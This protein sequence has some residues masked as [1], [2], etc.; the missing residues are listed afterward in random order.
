MISK[1][2]LSLLLERLIKAHEAYY[3]IQRDFSMGDFTFDALAQLHSDTSQYVLVKRAKL[4]EAH[5]HEYRFFLC[6]DILDETYLD[7]LLDFMIQNAI[8][9]VQAEPNH[10]TSYVSLV[11]LSRQACSDVRRKII[12][13]RWR[14]NLKFGFGGWIDLRLALVVL[15]D[16]QIYTNG[17]GK[18]MRS[19]LKA[20]LRL[21]DTVEPSSIE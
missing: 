14:K 6:A 11:I 12:R 9:L 13:T 1:D 21:S 2:P 7:E 18:E 4:W 17:Q 16:H 8:D 15:G 3:D 5:T 10:M 19:V 20:N